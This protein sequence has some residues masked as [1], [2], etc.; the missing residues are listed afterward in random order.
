M[1]KIITAIV[2][3][4]LL[5][6]GCSDHKKSKDITKI[7]KAEFTRTNLLPEEA[8]ILLNEGIQKIQSGK[9][10]D[11]ILD[12]QDLT[13]LYPK[14]IVA[15]YNLG[16]AYAKNNQLNEAIASWEEVVS[17]DQNYAD[18][19]YNLGQAYKMTKDNRKAVE[20]LVRYTIL[21]PSDPQ[22]SFIKD[23]IAKM[24]E[25]NIGTGVVGR[26]SITDKVDFKNNIA[27]SV[28]DFLNP[29]IPVIYTCIEIVSAPK[30]TNIE[31]NWYYRAIDNQKIPVNKMKF[32][33]E[34]SKNVLL[35]LKKPKTEWPS[36]K[37]EFVILVNGKENTIV[38]YNINN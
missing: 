22:I 6:T 1:K 32:K 33:I 27:L 7:T 29:A 13:K 21:R 11:A 3:V 12:F 17:I 20:N 23:E 31:A 16:L 24:K 15:H 2:L 8:K 5:I 36:G 19:Y 10:N 4:G 18:A 35:S 38:P 25:P 26:I 14:L 37:Y 34:G 28:K 30:D 9:I